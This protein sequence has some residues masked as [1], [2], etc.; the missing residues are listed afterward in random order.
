MR[1]RSDP[2]GPFSSTLAPRTMMASS[3]SGGF[4]NAPENTRHST[5]RNT[6]TAA[7]TTMFTA[8]SQG[9]GS[10]AFFPRFHAHFQRKKRPKH[11]ADSISQR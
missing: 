4:W 10:G 3:P 7:I 9:W 6:A 2:L 11:T 8:R 5:A 1:C